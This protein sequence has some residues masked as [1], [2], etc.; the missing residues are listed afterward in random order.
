MKTFYK[1]FR[2]L[3]LTA[4]AAFTA[5]FCAV[6]QQQPLTKL[7]V[8]NWVYFFRAAPLAALDDMRRSVAHIQPRR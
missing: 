8:A 4:L 3:G 5:A 1:E 7:D 6:R 2:R